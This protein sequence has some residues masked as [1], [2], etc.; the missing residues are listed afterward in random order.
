MVGWCV[1]G[2]LVE[3]LVFTE[4]AKQTRPLLDAISFWRSGSGAEVD[5]VIEIEGQLI[6]I[7]SKSSFRGLTRSLA[8]FREKYKPYRTIVACSDTLE[9]V[10]GILYLPFVFISAL[11]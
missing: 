6:A 5:F 8:N 11:V 2:A 1:Y 9:D 7:E 3:N 4:L 10:N